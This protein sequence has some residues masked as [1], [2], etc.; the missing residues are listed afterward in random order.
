[1]KIP[2]AAGG[3]GGGGKP[4]REQEQQ[5]AWHASLAAALLPPPSLR[6]SKADCRRYHFAKCQN[7]RIAYY[8]VATW[9]F[10]G[11]W[12]TPRSFVALETTVVALFRPPAPLNLTADARPTRRKKKKLTLMRHQ[13]EKPK[14]TGPTVTDNHTSSAPRKSQPLSRP[15]LTTT[16]S[17]SEAAKPANFKTPK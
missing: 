7:I 16:P 5:E 2:G 12:P 1:M 4:D 9:W 10:C 11:S 3:V 17:T 15:W 8:D 13:E 6:R 14:L